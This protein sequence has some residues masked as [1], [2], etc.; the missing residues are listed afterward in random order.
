MTSATTVTAT[1]KITERDQDHLVQV[2]VH[3]RHP[4]TE[5]R[6]SDLTPSLGPGNMV[7]GEGQ[8]VNIDSWISVSFFLIAIRPFCLTD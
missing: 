6:E 1:P 4:S 8:K 3:L 7:K 5:A 2:L